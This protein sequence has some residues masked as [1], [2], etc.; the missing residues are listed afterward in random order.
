MEMQATITVRHTPERRRYELLD[1]D[2][3]IGKAHYLPHESSKG[4]ERIFYHTT[5]S[6]DYAGQGLAA[7]LVQG[8]LDDTLATGIAV[9]PVCPYVKV[10]LRKHPDYQ[11]RMTGVHREHLTAVEHAGQQ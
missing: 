4:P 3:V 8:A 10:W 6:E 9:V 11:P 1:G 7:R 2:A 5:V